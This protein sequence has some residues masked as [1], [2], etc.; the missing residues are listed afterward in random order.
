MST[1]PAGTP[2]S[3]T[4]RAAPT[5]AHNPANPE[6]ITST[7][8]ICSTPHPSD[9]AIGTVASA[10]MVVI[11]RCEHRH[12]VLVRATPAHAGPRAVRHSVFPPAAHSGMDRSAQVGTHRGRHLQRGTT[13]LGRALHP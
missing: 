9:V 10:P 13:A 7:A 12:R 1:L 5:P 8:F 3:S 4:R 6:P 11:Y 2:N